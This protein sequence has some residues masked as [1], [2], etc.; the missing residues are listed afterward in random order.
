MSVEMVRF[1]PMHARSLI[2]ERETSSDDSP[3]VNAA[4]N[5]YGR[6]KCD[7]SSGRSTRGSS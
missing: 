6:N 1:P 2:S 4:M 7:P 5:I 3:G